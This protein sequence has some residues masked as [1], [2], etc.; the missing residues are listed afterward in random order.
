MDA[1]FANGILFWHW[2]V[3]GFALLVI[4]VLTPGT[5]CMW[6]GFAAF[7]T[8]I[9]A[10][11]VPALGAPAEIVLFALLSLAAVGLWFKLRPMQGVNAGGSGLNQRGRSYIGRVLTLSEGIVNGIGQ[12]RLEDSVWRVAGPSLP[13]G[14]RVRVIGSEGTTLRVEQ[15]PENSD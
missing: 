6:I 3:L 4:E 9:L 13:R 12:V 7:A 2:W 15:A 5:F 1:L 8:G 14:A 11:L 10:W